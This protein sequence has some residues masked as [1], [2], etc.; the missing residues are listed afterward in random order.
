MVKF[1]SLNTGPSRKCIFQAYIFFDN[2]AKSIFRII[3][4]VALD[5]GGQNLLKKMCQSN[6]TEKL[7]TLSKEI[8]AGNI[9]IFARHKLILAEICHSD[10]FFCGHWTFLG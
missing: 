8:Q 1:K 7:V 5:L 2:D 6:L 10:W 3:S 9:Y 4:M